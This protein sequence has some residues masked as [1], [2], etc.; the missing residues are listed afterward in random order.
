M[1][2]IWKQKGQFVISFTINSHSHDLLHVFSV[3]GD[4]S[5]DSDSTAGSESKMVAYPAEV[6]LSQMDVAARD[7]GAFYLIFVLILQLYYLTLCIQAQSRMLPETLLQIGKVSTMWFDS[8]R[9]MSFLALKSYSYF[10]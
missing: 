5:G 7:S 2:I 9:T 6:V 1:M 4:V 3:E 8:I 10:T